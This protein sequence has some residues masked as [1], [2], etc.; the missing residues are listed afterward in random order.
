M[1]LYQGLILAF[2]FRMVT[3][4]ILFIMEIQVFYKAS[5]CCNMSEIDIIQNLLLYVT[6]Y[7]CSD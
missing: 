7:R 1:L 6:V 5:A 2:Q 3:K 4:D